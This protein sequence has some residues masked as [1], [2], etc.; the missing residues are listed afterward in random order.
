MPA[1]GLWRQ[2]NSS[3]ATNLK[4]SLDETAHSQRPVSLGEMSDE[5]TSI[6]RYNLP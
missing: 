1:E 5:Q 4:H 6:A 2:Y 3:A